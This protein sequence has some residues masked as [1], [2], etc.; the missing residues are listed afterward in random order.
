MQ[1][2]RSPLYHNMAV[3]MAGYSHLKVQKH[4]AILNIITVL[5][6]T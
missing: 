4:Y 5:G 6:N 1:N 2:W 3:P